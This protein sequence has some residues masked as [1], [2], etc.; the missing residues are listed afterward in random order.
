MADQFSALGLCTID[1][2]PPFRGLV[3]R[4]FAAPVLDPQLAV[5]DPN[6][7]GRRRGRGAVEKAALQLITVRFP[8]EPVDLV[9]IP[10]GAPEVPPSDV[11]IFLADDHRRG[12][13]N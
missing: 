13:G 7:R 12:Q 3:G 11:R 5:S 2:T 6:P 4:A 8:L 9:G 10:A 1:G